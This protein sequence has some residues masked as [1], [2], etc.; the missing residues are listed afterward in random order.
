[1]AYSSKSSKKNL[2]KDINF[3]NSVQNINLKSNI[4]NLSNNDNLSKNLADMSFELEDNTYSKNLEVD[5]NTNVLD[6]FE[7]TSQGYHKLSDNISV[8]TDYFEDMQN[9]SSNN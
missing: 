8:S 6:K 5:P 3:S 7:N 1:M 9:N 2:F 4:A